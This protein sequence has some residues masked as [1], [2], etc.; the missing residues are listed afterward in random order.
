M[1]PADSKS[2][3]SSSSYK[4][5]GIFPTNTWWGREKIRYSI[6]NLSTAKVHSSWPNPVTIMS[7]T[8]VPIP[9]CVPLNTSSGGG[10]PYFLWP[11]V[12]SRVYPVRSKRAWKTWTKTKALHAGACPTFI[13]PFI[14]PKLFYLPLF[15]FHL[16]LCWSPGL[17]CLAFLSVC[18]S[19]WLHTE[20]H[21]YSTLKKKH[22]TK[23]I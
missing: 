13:P 2:G 5:L 22:K 12:T 16:D 18:K 6:Q 11:V 3:T 20:K 4:S 1:A 23:Y 17:Y 14:K 10:P 15:L 19:S 21:F 7:Y 8:S 9:G